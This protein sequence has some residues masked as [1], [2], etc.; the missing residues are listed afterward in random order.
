[1]KPIRAEA[2]PAQLCRGIVFR[3]EHAVSVAKAHNSCQGCGRISGSG[4]GKFAAKQLVAL[5]TPLGLF[6]SGHLAPETSGGH[7]YESSFRLELPR[8]TVGTHHLFNWLNIN[9]QLLYAKLKR[10][11]FVQNDDSGEDL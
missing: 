9:R 8:V 5:G 2:I 10:Y 3:D 7:A 4:P 6:L 11:G 1:M